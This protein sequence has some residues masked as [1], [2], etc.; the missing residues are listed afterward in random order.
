[1]I[2]KIINEGNQEEEKGKIESA[3]SDMGILDSLII[4]ISLVH[5]LLLALI[6]LL[7]HL[8]CHLRTSVIIL[9]RYLSILHCLSLIILRRTHL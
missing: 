6:T 3:L 1:M 8:S 2:Q 9:I 4:R 5:S 7:A